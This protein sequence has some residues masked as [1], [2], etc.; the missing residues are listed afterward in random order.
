[1]LLNCTQKIFMEFN[2]LLKNILKTKGIFRLKYKLT[3][4]NI[5]KPL[6]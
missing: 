6:T 1:M 5:M 3:L 4:V 2:K